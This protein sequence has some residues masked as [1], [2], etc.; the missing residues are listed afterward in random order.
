MTFFPPSPGGMIFTSGRWYLLF[1]PCFR[2]QKSISKWIP[3]A[4]ITAN[5]LV[6]RSCSSFSLSCSLK[7]VGFWGG[8]GSL[9]P[10]FWF[11]SLALDFSTFSHEGSLNHRRTNGLYYLK[12]GETLVLHPTRDFYPCLPVT[13]DY[14]P[15]GTLEHSGSCLPKPQT[16]HDFCSN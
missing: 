13:Q 4:T 5:I 6:V 12:G 14:G 1:S 16:Y 8:S 11:L 7:I 2:I 10:S 3:K 15:S 9:M